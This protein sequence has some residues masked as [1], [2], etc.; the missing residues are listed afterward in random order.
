[1]K[2]FIENFGPVKEFVIDIKPL[3]I[4]VGR[5]NAGK[6]Y[7]SLL[8]EVLNSSFIDLI[9]ILY[10]IIEDIKYRSRFI[11]YKFFFLEDTETERYNNDKSE[12]I[13]FNYESI[14]KKI[15]KKDITKLME[16]IK[17]KMDTLTAPFRSKVKI[18]E[19][20]Q[21]KA[22]SHLIERVA[23]IFSNIFLNRITNKFSSKIE[24][25][26][27]F[28]SQNS[29]IIIKNDNIEISIILNKGKEKKID[30][31]IDLLNK[32]EI[33]SKMRK[34]LKDIENEVKRY[35]SIVENGKNREDLLKEILFSTLM[36]INLEIVDLIAQF[37]E[38]NFF[39]T[40]Y[41]PAT[42]S[43][44][45][46]AYETIATAYIQ[47]APESITRK[48]DFPTL[49]GV[50]AD[51]IKNLFK[52][53][54][55]RAIILRK[56]QKSRDFIYDIIKYIEK[57][58]IHGKIEFK[59]KKGKSIKGYISYNIEGKEVPL[60]RASSMVSEL[61]GLLIFLK[62]LLTPG[63]LLIFEEPES[64]LH[65]ESQLKIAIVIT[66]LYKNDI[67]LIITTHSDYFLHQINNFIKISKLSP[68]KIKKVFG[69]DLTI[70]RKDVSI[71][72]FKY[73]DEN[74]ETLVKNLEFDEYGLTEDIFYEITKELFQ[75]SDEID[76]MINDE[77]YAK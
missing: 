3:M 63:D 31:K 4:F 76:D 68:E 52:S 48:I 20:I 7:I 21:E 19:K 27:N 38:K 46:Q 41:L 66:M 12:K 22:Y 35:F 37:I 34:N 15:D 75:T 42:R 59:K 40:L 9:D 11:V 60:Y 43:G 54:S 69:R 64:H 25:L 44:L 23:K 30:V 17:N 14:I 51:Y 39:N 45:I 53:E 28:K 61:S 10:Y 16:N 70:D 5:N 33:F 18:P 2:I 49:S 67:R 58:I 50:S 24:N 56:T 26:I 71:N 65:P 29:I 73:D 57:E 6:S 62:K 8:L 74:N 36:T 1:M 72:L 47:L 55:G 13:Y 77:L 32:N